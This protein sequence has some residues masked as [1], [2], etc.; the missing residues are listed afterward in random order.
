M[1]RW[2][3]MAMA[4]VVL[5]CG[6][7]SATA[8]SPIRLVYAGPIHGSAGGMSFS[9]SDI[10]VHVDGSYYSGGAWGAVIHYNEGSGAWHDAPMSLVGHYGTHM[11]FYVR[12]PTSTARFAIKATWSYAVS[13]M[14]Y[15]RDYWDNN[16]GANYYI[17]AHASA[18]GSTDGIVG[19]NAGLV[20]A[21]NYYKS[22]ATFPG[23]PR[24]YNQYVAGSIVVQNTSPTRSAGIR[25]T[26]D[27][28][29]TFTDVP[30]SSVTT[31][32]FGYG[33]SQILLCRFSRRIG[34][35]VLKPTRTVKFAV[36]YRD[37]TTGRE[38]WDNNF[39]QNYTVKSGATI[40]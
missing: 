8:Q 20:V 22:V 9:Y 37:E 33:S 19:G 23:Q 26:T 12:L 10:Y 4:I 21:S 15:S 25:M 24:L 28:W 7:F 39:E 31:L 18:L 32:G 40:R 16:G 36:Y 11:L 13:G 17:A 6:A 34:Y 14:S 35:R 5:L 2:I 30:V 27:N 3:K 38:Y 1:N 29:A